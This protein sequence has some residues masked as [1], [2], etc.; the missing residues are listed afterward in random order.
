MIYVHRAVYEKGLQNV[1]QGVFEVLWMIF[2][3]Y[4]WLKYP[5]PFSYSNIHF[6]F[7]E[8]SFQENQPRVTRNSLSAQNPETH[9]ETLECCVEPTNQK[10]F[11]VVYWF[12]LILKA[13]QLHLKTTWKSLGDF[14]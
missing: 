7:S 10:N 9:R 5:N 3:S 13:N 2:I 14:Q 11:L 6:Q 12:K 8:L 1:A 4:F